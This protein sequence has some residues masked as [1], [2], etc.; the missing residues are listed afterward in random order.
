[1]PGWAHQLCEPGRLG[2]SRSA[3]AEGYYG[4]LD[5]LWAVT[6]WGGRFEVDHVEGRR[7]EVLV[8]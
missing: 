6:P 4:D 7:A 2:Q 8:S 5:P 1:M 3:Q